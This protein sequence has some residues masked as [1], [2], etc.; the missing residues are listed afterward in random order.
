MQVVIN[1]ISNAVKFTKTGQVTIRAR[2]DGDQ[3][4]V[5]VTDQG[6]GIAVA[7]QQRLFEKFTQV[8]DPLTGKPQ[9]TGLGLAISKEIVDR[10]DGK[11][12]VESEIGR[13]STFSFAIP[14]LRTEAQALETRFQAAT[15][16]QP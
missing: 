12:W 10:H 1:L 6:I 8:G 15:E 3:V 14:I 2:Q 13:G 7:D 4:V 16:K 11:I 5:S 9:G